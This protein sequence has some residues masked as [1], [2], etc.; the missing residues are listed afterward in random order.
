MTLWSLT[1][2][3]QIRK[4]AIVDDDRREAEVAELEAEDAGF[5]PFIVEGGPFRKIEDLTNLISSNAQAAICDHRLGHSGFANFSGAKLVARLYDLHIPAIL[6]SQYAEMDNGISIRACRD[7]IPVLLNRDETDAIS[8]ARGIEYCVNELRGQIANARKP[9]RTLLRIVDIGQ[10]AG[11]K[12]IDVIIPS[13]NPHR[14][15]RLPVSLLP[16]SISKSH[17]KRGERL[18]VKTNIG[19]EKASELYFKDF[20]VATELDSDDELA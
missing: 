11:E 2:D 8:I 13:W 1:Y 17:L 19:A 5:E 12:V 3:Y 4:I 16:K 6:I 20:E 15:V 9:H 10:E 18:F 14:A 7:K